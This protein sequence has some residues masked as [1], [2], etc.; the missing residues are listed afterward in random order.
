M[1]RYSATGPEPVVAVL[2][3]SGTVGRRLATTLASRGGVRLRLGARNPAAAADAGICRID[4]ADPAALKAFIDGAAVLVNCVGPGLRTRSKVALAALEHAVPYLDPSG[5][6]GLAA[7]IAGAAGPGPLP[8]PLVLGA[9]AVPGACG[10]LARWLATAGAPACSLTGFVLT[11][12]PLHQATAT[13]FLLAMMSQRPQ[14]AATGDQAGSG[15]ARPAIAGLRLPYA[16]E[17]LDAFPVLS[18]EVAALSADLGMRAEM[19]QA[20]EQ[21]SAI[22]AFLSSIARRRAEGSTV[23][24][25][26]GQLTEV[27]A[28]ELAGRPPLHLIAWQAAADG[29]SRSAV[30]RTASSY[31]LTASM[32]ALA[33]EHL[34]AGRVPAGL[35]HADSLDPQLVAELPGL[36][37]STC[38]ATRPGPLMAWHS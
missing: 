38:L 6:E 29:Q 32:L 26:A 5:D 31:Q 16:E 3:A 27:V 35:Q 2:G 20:F 30:L 22:L 34:I 4:P 19:F 14:P 17:P 10:L 1:P 25:L 24:Q 13:E 28:A 11:L 12:E 21:G 8:V 7:R 23:R 9:G 33:A 36:D 18:R 37:A 15:Q